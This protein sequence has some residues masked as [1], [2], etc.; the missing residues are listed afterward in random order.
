MPSGALRWR[1]LF[2]RRPCHRPRH[3]VRRG[4]AWHPP[5]RATRTV[6]A[7]LGARGPAARLV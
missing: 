3:G 5:E 4:T 1:R 2:P 7:L 6:R